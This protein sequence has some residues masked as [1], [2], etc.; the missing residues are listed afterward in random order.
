[1]M[2]MFLTAPA[3]VSDSFNIYQSL[4]QSDDLSVVG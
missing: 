4:R 3:P 1:M 2:D